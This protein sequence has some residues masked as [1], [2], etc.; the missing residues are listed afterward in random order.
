MPDT[1][2][3]SGDLKLAGRLD[4]RFF[5]LL[6]AIEATGSINRA[7]AT[8]GYS[9][10]GAWMVLEAASHMATQPLIERSPGGRRGGG[11]RMTATAHELLA[12]WR[13]VQAAHQAFLHAQEEWLLRQPRLAR[14]LKRLSVKATA[15][16]QFAGTVHGV[17]WG[18]V[19]TQV[20]LQLAGGQEI[21]ATLST[22]RARELDLQAGKDAIAMVNA[23]AVMLV[24]DFDGFRISARNQLAGTISQ[25]E[26]DA[27]SSL[28]FVTLPGGTAV[29]SAATE[30]EV[31]ACGLIVGQPVTALFKAYSVVIAAAPDGAVA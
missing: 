3:L 2:L 28:I 20:M 6:E 31:A 15:R 16:N 13:R 7:A 12:A 24:A 5:A 18:P 10:R 14:V 26:R 17:D 8:A 27:G 29:T 30:D 21:V 25:I 1:S 22:R 11:S 4:A 9:Y 19:T 23:S